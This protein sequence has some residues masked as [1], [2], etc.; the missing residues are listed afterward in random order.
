MQTS[1]KPLLNIYDDCQSDLEMIYKLEDLAQQKL[2]VP[3]IS[4][5]DQSDSYKINRNDSNNLEI[6]KAIPI[7]TGVVKNVNNQM[8]D[9]LKH[10]Y[11]RRSME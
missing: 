9:V 7:I 11:L 3:L 5:Y 1:S 10:D 8:A 2:K 6:S 4:N